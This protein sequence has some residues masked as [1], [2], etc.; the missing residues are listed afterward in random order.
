MFLSFLPPNGKG[1][2]E[3][4]SKKKKRSKDTRYESI[5][6]RVDSI[7]GFAMKEQGNCRVRRVKRPSRMQ[8]Y[9]GIKS[10]REREE[11]RKKLCA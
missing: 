10:A 6:R 2:K 1:G 5:L 9:G 4:K 3:M 8:S 7:A 11:E